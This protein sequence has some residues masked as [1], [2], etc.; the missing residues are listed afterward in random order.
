MTNKRN[1]YFL[2]FLSAVSLGAGYLVY[3]LT[4]IAGSGVSADG[5]LYLSSAANLLKGRG[6]I[7]L[8]GRPLTL[9]PP[10]YP[11]ILAFISL[12]TRLDVYLI[13]WFLNILTF[14]LIVFFS[15]ILFQRLYP[16]RLLLASIGSLVVAA[17]PA[18][19]NTSASILSDPLFMLFVI[20]FL[21]EA[22]AFAKDTK[23]IHLVWMG[24][25][26]C[27]A[28]LDRYAGLVLVLCGA[29][30][31]LYFHRRR[32]LHG[33]II[34]AL[35]LV[36]GLPL[37][38]WSIFHNYPLTGN[39]FGSYGAANIPGNIYSSIQK[40]LYWFFPYS[41]IQIVTPFGLAAILLLIL[42]LLNK[43]SNW[44]AWFQCI[45]ADPA[46]TNSILIVVYLGVLVFNT[47]YLDTRNLFFERYHIILLTPLLIVF[48]AVYEHLIPPRNVT[49]R[50]GIQPPTSCA[51]SG[52]AV[53]APR[54]AE[55]RPGRTGAKKNIKDLVLLFVFLIWLVYPI[56]KIWENEKNTRLNGGALYN[57]YNY[58]DIQTSTFLKTAQALPADQK[59][60]SNYEAAAWFYL[61]QD[62][63]SLPREDPKTRQVD[64]ASLKRFRNSIGSQAGGY[65]IWFR[66]INYRDDLPNLNQLK[67]MVKLKPVF[68]SAVGDIYYIVSNSP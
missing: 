43:P 12:I 29:L 48:F 20:L 28:S 8:N 65:I 11:G 15:G 5:A 27:L 7:D 39:L 59:I 34:S 10:F 16:E 61:R 56:S 67:Q 30:F 32:I 36:S 18:L 44:K 45:F 4:S 17:S 50:G 54:G 31:L 62:I 6:L 49:S 25:L 40:I 26:A 66:T 33:L 19:I 21:L 55:A 35:F 60:Y 22:A 51:L 14:G 3:R 24:L 13:G 57:R 41:L 2:L 63:L 46:F 23:W 53:S 64:P 68:T 58:A 42:I 1:L 52:S 38:L 37:I 9:A 47:S